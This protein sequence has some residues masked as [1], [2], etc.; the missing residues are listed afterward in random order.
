MLRQVTPLWGKTRRNNN[1]CPPST[2]TRRHGKPQVMESGRGKPDPYAGQF[3][4][5]DGQL[6]QPRINS[7]AET[8]FKVADATGLR[9]YVLGRIRRIS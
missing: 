1:A 3:S 4:L 2:G 6:Y 5:S 7:R 8:C 9:Q